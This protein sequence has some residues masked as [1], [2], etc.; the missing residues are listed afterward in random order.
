MTNK[1]TKTFFQLIVIK[2]VTKLNPTNLFS[3][4]T[5]KYSKLIKSRNVKLNSSGKSK[6]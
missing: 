4:I 5:I 3:K 2:A 6:N 1:N